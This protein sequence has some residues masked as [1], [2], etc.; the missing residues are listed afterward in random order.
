MSAALLRMN[1]VRDVLPTLGRRLTAREGR[2]V[3]AVM[4]VMQTNLASRPPHV[5]PCPR[6]ERPLDPDRRPAPGRVEPADRL[7]RQLLAVNVR[8]DEARKGAQHRANED[9]A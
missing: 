2:R 4:R 8:N 3:A 1:S 9:V 5:Q 6:S 7:Y